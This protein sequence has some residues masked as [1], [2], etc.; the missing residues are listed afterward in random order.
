MNLCILKVLGMAAA[1]AITLPVVAMAQDNLTCGEFL[2]MDATAQIA[3]LD[4]VAAQSIDHG[5]GYRYA[6]GFT[7]AEKLADVTY[8][9]TVD[10]NGENE[11]WADLKVINL[12]G[13]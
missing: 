12:I 2:E 9:C 13:E 3:A 8:N 1:V 10:D 4:V 11:A 7:D 5:T 6:E